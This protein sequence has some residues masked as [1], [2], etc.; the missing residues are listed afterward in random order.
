MLHFHE[1]GDKENADRQQTLEDDHNVLNLFGTGVV[2]GQVV[3]VGDNGVVDEDD[4]E[5]IGHLHV[6]DEAESDPSCEN[7]RQSSFDVFIPQLVVLQFLHSIVLD[8]LGPEGQVV[9]QRNHGEASVEEEKNIGGVLHSDYVILPLVHHPES[10]KKRPN[11][12][13]ILE[14]VVLY[15]HRCNPD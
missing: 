14:D 12:T 9:D 8:Q 6:W 15:D 11:Q 5:D 3:K 2:Q 13:L 10:S 7:A 4:E 1:K